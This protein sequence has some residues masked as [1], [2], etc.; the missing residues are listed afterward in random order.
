MIGAQPM[1]KWND[2]RDMS[3]IHYEKIRA[4]HVRPMRKGVDV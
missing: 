2:T 1:G 3:F 4:S